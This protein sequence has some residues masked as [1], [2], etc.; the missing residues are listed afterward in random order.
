LPYTKYLPERMG[1]AKLTPGGPFVAGSHQE[2]TL[3]YTAGDFG[4]DDTG[5]LKMR[6]GR[7]RPARPGSLALVSAL[8]QTA[9]KH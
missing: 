9:Y 5:M 8:C 2:L 4:I 6:V 7:Q 1:S 3:T